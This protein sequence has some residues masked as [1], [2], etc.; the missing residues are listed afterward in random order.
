MKVPCYVGNLN[1][2]ERVLAPLRRFGDP[3]VDTVAPIPYVAMQTTFD[4]LFPSGRLGYWKSGLT[5]RISD[6][7][8]AATV[9]YASRMPSP[10]TV[11]LFVEMHGAYARV[12]KTDTAY[13][14]RDM[15]YD[16]VVL[17]GWADPGDTEHNISWTRQLYAA[18]EPHLARAAYVNDLGDE[19]RNV[20]A[21]PM[22]TTTRAWRSSRQSTIQ[23]TSSALT[24]I[25][26]QRN[27]RALSIAL[28]ST[29][30]RDPCR[31]MA[32]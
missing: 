5:N 14:N 30:Q 4:G 12:G 15:Q 6:E 16:L 29:H 28:N 10:H 20:S 23:P 19:V 31:R 32:V 21:A 13:Y 7:V 17:S 2:G 3:V 22:A 27:K 26:S 8:I 24:R 18:W 9:E 1:D 25:L 11:I